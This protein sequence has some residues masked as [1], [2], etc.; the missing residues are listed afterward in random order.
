[1]SRTSKYYKPVDKLAKPGIK[2]ELTKEMYSMGEIAELVGCTSANLSILYKSGKF[3]KF[4][5]RIGHKLYYT[6]ETIEKWL[7]TYRPRITPKRTGSR[8]KFT[9]LNL[10]EVSEHDSQ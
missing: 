4:D 8:P 6:R 1:M 3:P 7:E 9:Q 5:D 2:V 10:L